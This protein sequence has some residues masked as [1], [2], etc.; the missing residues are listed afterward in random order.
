MPESEIDATLYQTVNKRTRT[1]LLLETKEADGEAVFTVENP[2]LWNAEKPYLYEL[3]FESKG[4][5]ITQKVG[6]RTIAISD[7]YELLINGVPVKLQGVNHHDTHPT[8]GWTLT[9]ED[10]LVPFSAEKG[11]GKDELIGL[12]NQA[13]E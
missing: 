11:V 5:V 3:R 1:V 4:E 8:N 2:I 10:I 13:C 6:F 9:E 12:L 7:K